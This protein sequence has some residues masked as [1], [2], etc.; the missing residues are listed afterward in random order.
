[1]QVDD[2]NQEEVSEKRDFTPLPNGKYVAMITE[3][4]DKIS[5]AG[6]KYVALTATI[7]DGEH[8][9]RLL[10]P[11]LN[12]KHPDQKVVRYAR[13]ELKSIQVATG[14]LNIKDTC[15]I[16]NIPMVITVAS[17][18]DKKT[19]ELKNKITKY[20]CARIENMPQSAPTTQP[21][22]AGGPGVSP[23]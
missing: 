4:I 6:F 3:A 17:Y 14:R 7:G 8:E 5:E 19:G 21:S 23:F 22:A 11:N 13:Q 12:L 9:G 10:W 2:Y 16:K 18:K 20:E 15:E 1:M